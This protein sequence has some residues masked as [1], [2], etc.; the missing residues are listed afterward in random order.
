MRGLIDLMESVFEGF[1]TYSYSFRC[2]LH[3]PVLHTR[4]N[5]NGSRMNGS[6]PLNSMLFANHITFDNEY[7]KCAHKRQ[8]IVT[9]I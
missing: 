2:W 6:T 5:L 1:L 3:M 9:A 8:K 7:M 4:D